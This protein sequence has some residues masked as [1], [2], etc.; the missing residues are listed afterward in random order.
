[1]SLRWREQVSIYLAPSRV[2]LARWSRGLRS[3][4]VLSA[5]VDVPSGVRGD[6]A[7]V[8][9]KLA[10]VLADPAWHRAEARVVVADHRWA[11]YAVVPWPSTKLD[12]EGHLTHARYVLADTYGDSVAGWSVTLSDAPP[13]RNRIA[14]AM[15]ATL[16]S[17]LEDVLAPARL[18]LVSLQP[19]LLV[20]FNAWRPRLASDN[21]WFVSLD[22]GMVSA[23]HLRDGAWDRV[24][25]A[26]LPRD[27]RVELERLQTFGRLARADGEGGR[28]FVDAP[29]WMR[30]GANVSPAIEWLEEDEGAPNRELSVLQRRDA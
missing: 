11:R 20:A 2:S 19:R 3:R 9:E 18:E 26:M 28:M 25:M 5:E 17:S 23:V 4:V 13:G 8:L 21:A 7:P 10:G 27:W 6:L 24:H 22:E 30:R 16:R 29:A 15:P 12:A 1:V 14:C